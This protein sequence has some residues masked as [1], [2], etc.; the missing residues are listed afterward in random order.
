MADDKDKKVSPWHTFNKWLYDGSMTSKIPTELLTD[1]SIG[2]MN[3]LYYFRA[4]KYGVVISNLFNNWDLFTLDRVEVLYFMK[5]CVYRTGYK[6][7]FNNKVPA[8][9][10]K[11]HDYLK[12]RHPFLKSDEVFMLVDIIDNS[13]EKDSIYETLGIY[14]PG[15]AKKTTKAQLEF[16]T[17]DEKKKEVKVKKED[18][19]L[20]SMLGDFE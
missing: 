2:I 20:G 11:L 19:D 10:S 16:F 12:E 3:L 15:K 1:K 4:S 8:K 7:P 18:V 9:K 13:D 5:E 14:S 6:P 17:K